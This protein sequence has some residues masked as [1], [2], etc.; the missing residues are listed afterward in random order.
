M[1]KENVTLSGGFGTHTNSARAGYL[2]ICL[3]RAPIAAFEGIAVYLRSA[4]PPGAETF[5]LY[6][7]EN[8]RLTQSHR[9]RLEA[10]GVKFVY[11]AMG[12]QSR[13]NTQ[14]EATLAQIV[15]DPN[16]AISVAAEIIYETSVELMN[17]LLSDPNLSAYSH[18]LEN[19]S[20]AVTT[21]VLK[22]KS[23]FSHLFAASHHDFY[24]ATHMVN[25]ATWMVP[26]AY[27]LGI[28]DVEELNR[29]C[30]AGIL[31]DIG[32]VY[33]P[34][35]IL[36]K[37][38]RLTPDEWAVIR[39]HPELGCKHLETYPNIPAVVREVTRHHHE[40]LDGSG[41]PDALKGEQI[42]L[43]SRICGVVDSFD[44]M[45]AFRPF[46]SKTMTVSEALNIIIN[47]AP[48]KYDEKVVNAFL[49]LLRTASNEGVLSEPLQIGKESEESGENRRDFPRFPISC[50]AKAHVLQRGTGEY[51]ERPGVAV[52]AHS[53]S[54][55]GLAFLMQTPI[56][57]GEYVRVYLKGA[58]T[59]SKSHDGLT[60]RC[61]AYRDGWY[62]VGMKFAVPTAATQDIAAVA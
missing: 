26:L 34:P 46:K 17:E 49:D 35:E 9:E 5:N 30:Q 62:E 29:I 57:V 31:H 44:A 45:T 4:N 52:V 10:A 37:K 6:S 42:D 21:L 61:R 18:R 41:Y 20:R 60:V 32:K 3:A 25:V 23:A 48:R 47:E 39:S 27:A 1:N 59:L 14:V 53:M 50:P 38:G 8:V 19:V 54:R 12:Q 58:G 7:S 40:R 36:N 28:E 11:V 55:G 15:A 33:V 16:I 56:R 2:P 51:H 22:D 43:I 13:F 24:T